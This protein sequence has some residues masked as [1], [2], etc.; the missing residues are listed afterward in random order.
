MTYE[1][2]I[3]HFYFILMIN[4]WAAF[5]VAVVSGFVL[6]FF[7]GGL[8]VV[9]G[10][11]LLVCVLVAAVVSNSLELEA[12]D[13]CDTGNVVVPVAV[14][15]DIADIGEVVSNDE[16]DGEASQHIGR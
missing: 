13:P 9:V 6:F 15:G 14:G 12:V 5:V 10:D 3:F 7:F 16:L 1:I 2:S 11:L 8:F 4:T